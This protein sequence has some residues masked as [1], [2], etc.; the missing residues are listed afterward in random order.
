MKIFTEE[1]IQGFE[2]LV[3][4]EYSSNIP[5]VLQLHKS[6]IRA[7]LI[8][9]VVLLQNV[10][11]VLARSITLDLERSAIC[12]DKSV[13]PGVWPR[14]DR[15]ENTN[16]SLADSI[17][18]ISLEDFASRVVSGDANRITG[19]YVPDFG[20]FYVIQQSS[21]NSGSVSPVNGVLT[22]FMR[23]ASNRVIGLLAHNYASGFWFN[24]FPDESLIHVF[25]GDGR[26]ETY[27]LRDKF[28]FEAVNSNSMESDFI[29][30]DSGTK[31]SAL[32][33]YEEMYAGEPHLTL[34]TCIQNQDELNW[35]RM[36]L[37]ADLVQE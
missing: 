10:S 20:G 14:D 13:T 16:S 18:A 27:Q 3:N 35:G 30:L 17:L 2:S 25:F 9:S 4:S 12:E 34:Q 6:F 37:L 29:D 23:P 33:V 31:Y 7:A 28:R 19:V 5:E 26:M 8:T 15:S 36:F 24:K 21:S 32:Q 11:P 1:P 22:Q